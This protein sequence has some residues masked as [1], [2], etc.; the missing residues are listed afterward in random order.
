MSQST[1][2]QVRIIKNNLTHQ[3]VLYNPYLPLV[4]YSAVKS[5]PYDSFAIS[6]TIVYTF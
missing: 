2:R 3:I 5:N 4:L 6:A 1:C